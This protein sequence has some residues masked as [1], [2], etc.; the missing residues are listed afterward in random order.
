MSALAFNLASFSTDYRAS[1]AHEDMG[2]KE[3]SFIE[4]VVK[5]IGCCFSNPFT[6]PIQLKPPITL[7]QA[8]STGNLAEARELMRKGANPYQP[9]ERG[10][11][12][13]HYAKNNLALL[14]ILT[15]TENHPKFR[16]CQS[17]H[18]FWTIVRPPSPTS[19]PERAKELIAAVPKWSLKA[20]EPKEGEKLPSIAELTAGLKEE[21]E[22]QY[23]MMRQTGS[24]IPRRESFTLSLDQVK[25]YLRKHH[26]LLDTSLKLANEPNI[27][28]TVRPGPRIHSQGAAAFYHSESNSILIECGAGY[29]A[30]IYGIAFETMN[31]LGREGFEWANQLSA[32]GEISREETAFLD[33]ALEFKSLI[34]LTM[35][36]PELGKRPENVNFEIRWV[37][38]NTSLGKGLIAHADHSRFEYDQMCA[39]PYLLKHR[40]SFEERLKELR[41][42]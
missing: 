10:I 7:H 31:A 28:Q 18:D 12:G 39:I 16:D 37:M 25:A 26:P 11:T 24:S 19:L 9:D 29:A 1:K 3:P 8:C 5:A 32:S 2:F 20:I 34:A 23:E 22:R 6:Q 41:K 17:I 38:N 15:K 4:R 36:F 30:M 33:E 13:L 14:K 42:S 35:L 21:E 27:Q 40:A